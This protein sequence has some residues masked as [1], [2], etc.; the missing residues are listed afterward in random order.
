[1]KLQRAQK[2]KSEELESPSPVKTRASFCISVDREI[3]GPLCF[4]CDKNEEHGVLHKVVSTEVD[5]DVETCAKQ[6][7]D[8]RLLAKLSAGDMH[9]QDAFYHKKCMTALHNRVH[10]TEKTNSE[11]SARTSP[12]TIALAELASFIE[13]SK[14]DSEVAPIFKL[15][16]LVKLYVHRLQQLKA[17]VPDRVNSTRL[18]DRLLAQIPALRAQ[19]KGREVFLVYDKDIGA[20]LQFAVGNSNDS[21]AVHLAKAAQIVRKDMLEKKQNFNGTFISSC[22]KDSVPTSLLALVTMM[23]E[24]PNIQDQTDLGTIES[25]IALTISQLLLFNTLKHRSV[26]GSACHYIEGE[27]PLA[28]YLGLLVHAQT[29]SKELIDKLHKLGLSVSYDRVLSIS[30]AMANSVCMMYEEQNIVCPPKLKTDILT[31]AIVDN[32]DHNP[33]ARTAKDSFHG[34]AIS[35][36]QHPCENTPGTDR[37]IVVINP[38]VPKQKGILELPA[39]YTN[40]KPR[41]KI[42]RLQQSKA[43]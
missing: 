5:E 13:E 12:E 8:T 42:T 18:K 31:T 37:G 27:A 9:A 28:I 11:D 33:S 1:M 39:Q 34:T 35:L 3:I 7:R 36:T 21:N 29:R 17:C 10:A 30:A 38:S 40:L 20:A 22:Q 6:L 2:R 19:N 15:S 23:L 25:D 24:G 4:F 32:I 14:L 16:D 26:A 43:Q 41:L